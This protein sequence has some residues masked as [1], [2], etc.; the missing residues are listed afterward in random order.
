M[1]GTLDCGEVTVTLYLCAFLTALTQVQVGKS[2]S[3]QSNQE[4]K[5]AVDMGGR[6]EDSDP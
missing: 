1:W 3:E 2:A 4:L 6:A 5:N